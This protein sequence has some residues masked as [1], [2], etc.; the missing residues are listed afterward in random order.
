MSEILKKSGKA[1][2]FQESW[3]FITSIVEKS[4]MKS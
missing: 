3:Y 4:P 1:K 2:W